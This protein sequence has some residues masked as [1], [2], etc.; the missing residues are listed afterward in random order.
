[1]NKKQRNFV[2]LDNLMAALM[3]NE[4]VLSPGANNLYMSYEICAFACVGTKS[5][6]IVRELNYY[7]HNLLMTNYQPKML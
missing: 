2:I 6:D 3:L 1:M 4:D 7:N 5:L